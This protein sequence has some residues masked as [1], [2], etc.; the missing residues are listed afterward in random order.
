VIAAL[1]D[2]VLFGL[3]PRSDTSKNKKKKST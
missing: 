2:M 3:V 1:V